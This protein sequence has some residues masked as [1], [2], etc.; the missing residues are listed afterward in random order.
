MRQTIQNDWALS[1]LDDAARQR[2]EEAVVRAERRTSGEIV[3]MLVRASAATGHV[4]PL[5]LLLL[6]TLG[7]AALDAAGL[8][9]W[10]SVALLAGLSIPVAVGLS[11]V[12]F[13]RR[14]LTSRADLEGQVFMRAH[15]EFLSAGLDR[16]T[17]ATG[18]LIFVS[19]A[20]RRVVVLADRAISDLLPPQTWEAVRDALLA[21][22]RR[23]DTAGGFVAAIDLCADILEKHFPIRPDDVDELPNAPVIRS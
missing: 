3:P 12:P 21:G 9:N 2:L 18:V 16:T 22:I 1:I 8:S 11:R 5:L 15:L 19:W 14:L 4:A 13:L 20:E 10:W 6:C 17:G 23:G 7:L